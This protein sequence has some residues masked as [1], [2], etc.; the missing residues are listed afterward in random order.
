M[1][2]CIYLVS[3]W[4]EFQKTPEFFS[5]NFFT[6]TPGDVSHDLSVRD[7]ELP[8]VDVD[9]EAAF[10]IQQVYLKWEFKHP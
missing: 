3:L 10:A 9:I 2:S 6:L 5:T 8:Q 4:Q 7:A 1:L